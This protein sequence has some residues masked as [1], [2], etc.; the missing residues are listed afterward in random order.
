LATA[1]ARIM[2]IFR[3]KAVPYFAQ[4]N[5]LAAVDSAI[6]DQPSADCV[7]RDTTLLRCS[8]GLIVAKLVGRD[9]YDEL[10]SI[11]REVVRSKASHFL[12]QLELLLGDLAK[13]A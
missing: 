9:N 10:V 8:T 3:E 11:Y 12:P 4:F 2:A 7:D 5:S 6:N 1:T 13:R